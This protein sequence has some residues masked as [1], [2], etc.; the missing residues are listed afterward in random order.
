MMMIHYT[1]GVIKTLKYSTT[2]LT[3]YFQQYSTNCV[4]VQSNQLCSVVR[5]GTVCYNIPIAVQTHCI[6]SFVKAARL[7]MSMKVSMPLWRTRHLGVKAGL[8]LAILSYAG[9]R[10]P[11]GAADAKRQRDHAWQCS[12][13][14]CT[15]PNWTTAL[16]AHLHI[17][18][19]YSQPNFSAP[20]T[21]PVLLVRY[22]NFL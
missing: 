22:L 1:V 3:V 14:H 9:D 10:P 5:C 8:E 16:M 18:V 15:R 2:Q 13:P 12:A 17:N 20:R 4:T 19:Q 6:S 7:H 11:R 21:A